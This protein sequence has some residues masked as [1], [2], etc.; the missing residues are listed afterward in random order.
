MADNLDK[1]IAGAATEVRTSKVEQPLHKERCIS[2]GGLDDPGY[3]CFKCNGTGFRTFKTPSDQR[4]KARVCILFRWHQRKRPGAGRE[5]PR[6]IEERLSGPAARV[7]PS[8]DH[9]AQS[10]LSSLKEHGWPLP[11]TS[12]TRPPQSAMFTDPPATASRPSGDHAT[13][14]FSGKIGP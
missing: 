12:Q 5:N 2:C 4:A 13:W 7:F 9:A 8:A 3:P 10:L 14:L 1:L 11:R 6:S